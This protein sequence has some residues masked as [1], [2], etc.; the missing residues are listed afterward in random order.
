MCKS[1]KNQTRQNGKPAFVDPLMQVMVM[2]LYQVMWPMF[3]ALSPPLTSKLSM[4]KT[5]MH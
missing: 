5:S 2:L 4:T 3:M 1:Y